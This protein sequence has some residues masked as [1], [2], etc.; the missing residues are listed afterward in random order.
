MQTNFYDV[1]A[2]LYLYFFMYIYTITVTKGYLFYLT[3]VT[4]KE[5]LILL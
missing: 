5:Q 3:P 1:A 2:V 4:T